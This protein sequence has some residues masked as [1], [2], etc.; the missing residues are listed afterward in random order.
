[1]GGPKSLN[2][3]IF[4]TSLIGFFDSRLALAVHITDVTQVHQTL[5]CYLHLILKRNTI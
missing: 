2:T 4:N 5:R 1:M 3:L